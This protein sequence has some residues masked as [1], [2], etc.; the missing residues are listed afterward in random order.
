MLC[1]R[2]IFKLLFQVYSQ[3]GVARFK[4]QCIGISFR[5]YFHCEFQRVQVES[6]RDGFCISGKPSNHIAIM[7]QN[8]DLKYDNERLSRENKLL[9]TRQI[10]SYFNYIFVILNFIFT[11]RV[12]VILDL[13]VKRTAQLKLLK[14]TCLEK[15]VHLAKPE[16]S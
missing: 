11:R 13:L 10:L 5:R 15:N 14:M 16:N 7:K 4:V 3:N 2:F 9:R 8:I 1:F 6:W 12:N